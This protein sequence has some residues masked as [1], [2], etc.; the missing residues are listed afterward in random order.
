MCKKRKPS[1]FSGLCRRPRL[2]SAV[3]GA[4][5]HPYH[6]LILPFFCFIRVCRL[7]L[8]TGG[9]GFRLQYWGWTSAHP[10]QCLIL[11]SFC[12]ICG[13][14]L[15]L[16]TGGPGFRLQYWWLGLRAP[17]TEELVNLATC[18]ASIVPHAA[19]HVPGFPEER[20]TDT[21][22]ARA[23]IRTHYKNKA[24]R[25]GS[26]SSSLR[27]SREGLLGWVGLGGWRVHASQAPDHTWS[28]MCRGCPR[29]G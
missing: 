22:A 17:A 11:P 13:F 21:S 14:R 15:C 6:N 9:P 26:T 7:C 2:P 24:P 4:S 8:S 23:A 25:C 18:L 29:S 5:A 20:L 28:G 12:L 1:L 3:L 27:C 16:S 10:Y 19:E